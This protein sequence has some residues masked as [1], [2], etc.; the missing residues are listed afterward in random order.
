MSSAI[1]RAVDP[2]GPAT[3]TFLPHVQGLRAIA[4]LAVVVFHMWPT[5][6]PGGFAGVDVFF[7]IS[8]FLIT[9]HLAREIAGTGTVRLARFWARRARRLLP[10]ALTVL[11]FC[12]V[13]V[14]SPWF[15]P[16]AAMPSRLKE[17]L[18]STFYVEN[19]YLVATSANYLGHSGDPTLAQHYWSLSVE[20]QFYFVWPLLLVGAA[21]LTRRAGRA[22]RG[23]LLATVGTVT[24]VGFIACVW[25][26]AVDP[27]AAYFATFTR[28]WEFGVGGLL[29]LFPGLR[30]VHPV[31]RFTIGWGGVAALV[32]SFT[33]LNGQMDFP[34]YLALVPVVGAALVI[35]ASPAGRPW[36]ATRVIALPPFSFLGAISYSL[37]L[38]H[39]PL[40][41]VAPALPF[42]TGDLV[43]RLGLLIVTGS[44]AWVTQRFVEEP[45]RALPAL[46]SAR[47]RRTL[48]MT[49][50]AMAGVAVLTVGLAA[51]AMPRYDA[52]RQEIKAARA[53]PTDCFGAA[54]VLDSSCASAGFETYTPSASA[55]GMDAPSA[56]E[57]LV[58]FDG[59]DARTCTRGSEAP[60]AP[61]VFLIGDSHAFQYVDALADIAEREGW[62]LTTLL[63][64]GCPW[65]TTPL[66][67]DGPF[68]SAC[69]TW[70]A[71]VADTLMRREPAMIVTTAFSG[72]SY[73]TA[74]F[75]EAQDAAVRG[76]RAAW[77]PAATRGIP[78]VALVDNP[79]LETNPA[80]CLLNRAPSDCSTERRTALPEDEP[81]ARAARG[82]PSVRVLDFTDVYCDATTCSPVIGGAGAYRDAD[83][84]TASFVD[85]LAPWLG[86]SLVSTLDR[87]E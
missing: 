5:A 59:D 71:Q 83:H 20:E 63:K 19:W 17:I 81:F 50:G 75:S 79:A 13:V 25:F 23:V 16:V 64:G 86:A 41:L 48:W 40:I 24:V 49:A 21:L 4:V 44:V 42:W 53:A 30:A 67:D 27:A 22:G 46:V 68:G 57:C 87:R 56:G 38:W 12:A 35:A 37:Y 80:V 33:L 11:V 32:A 78:I 10:A 1:P 60:G 3:S 54:A 8:G 29:A 85:S 76:F 15:V 34:G 70:R 18:A 69:D 39:W 51:V 84:L 52:A 55:M 77:A 31:V 26:T 7:V 58:Q 73:A 9:A 14:S 82:L 61:E 45:I 6:L 47:P 36:F 72:T 28:V 43:Q 74:G 65:S 62:R 2:S 66:A